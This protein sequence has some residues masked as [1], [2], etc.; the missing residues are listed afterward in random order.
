MK[1]FIKH[2][3]AITIQ[4]IPLVGGKNASLGEMYTALSSKGVKVPE[5]FAVTAQ[6]YW[7]FL[8]ENNFVPPLTALLSKLDT[9]SF[10]NLS[11]IGTKARSLILAGAFPESL[12]KDILEAY[13]KL[14]LSVGPAKTFAVR[15]SA[16]AED[17]PNASFA[18]Q[19]ETYLNVKGA[20][21][22]I[23]AC[24][25]C[26]AS[27]F[28]DRAIKYR[29]DNGFE[30]MKVALSIGVQAMIRSDIASSGVMFT[31]DPDSG[32]ENVVLVSGA[33]GLGENVVQGSVNTDE[34]LVFKP[35]LEKVAQPIIA[36]KL[37]SKIK[38]MVYSSVHANDI[39]KPEEAIVNLD[40]TQAKRDQYVLNDK[41]VIQLA[42]WAG[43]I[44]Q[45][46][47][48]HMDIE[49]AK[50]GE[51]GKMYIVQARPE[52]VHGNKKQTVFKEYKLLEKGKILCTGAGLGNKI[53]SGKARILSSPT[54]IAKLNE[55]EILVTE[56]TDPDWD[57]VMKKAAAIITDQGGRTSH[58]AIVAR[59]IGAIAVVGTTNG[60]KTIVDG[61]IITVSTAKGDMGEIYDGLLKWEEKEINLTTI[62]K[63]S[64]KVMLILAHPDEAFRISLLP[65]DGVGLMRMEFIISNTIGIHPMALKHFDTINDSAAKEKIETITRLYNSKEDFFIQKLA[66]ATAKMAAA[67]YPKDVIVR[68]SDF[69]SNEYANLIGGK[70]FEPNEEN[71]MIGF[72]GASRYYH[73]LYKD[74]FE[75]ECKAMKIVRDEMGLTNIKL[76]IPFCRTISEAE[77]VIEVMRSCGLKQK[78][79]GLELFVM[80]EIPSNALLAE[81]FAKHFDGFSIG[82]NDLTQLTLGADRDSELL[83]EIFSP[84]DPAVMQLIEMTLSKA[85]KTKTHTGLCGQAP[86][87]YPAYAQFL[88]KN[89]IDSISF[90][91]DALIKGIENIA[92]AE[93]NRN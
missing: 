46:Y 81:E 84:F 40:T 44:Q 67:F 17:L 27:L 13:S 77:K 65:N 89:G 38:T 12:T 91:P 74:A 8:H 32:F 73:P 20:E 53:V 58:A 54:E 33:W 30:H 41:E 52:T 90:T 51:D 48:R 3:S 29:A 2:F 7:T 1:E 31:I 47:N 42:K 39:L 61:Q 11:D 60:T 87:D 78:E 62:P 26:Y 57:P 71:P 23:K 76:M 37:G 79:N 59:E 75:M 85:K 10:D 68:M 64:T 93:K 92:L 15:S 21:N 86:S 18:G 5:G 50:D 70:Q 34:F 24:H 82:S 72:R 4:D 80:I 19:Q 55:G 49:W 25:R 36:R 9:T 43:I 83:N 45:H 22:L 14:V 56:R 88:V 66:E 35:L 16:T 6:G 63:T 28:T 69:K